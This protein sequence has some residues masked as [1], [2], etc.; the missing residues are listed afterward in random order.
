MMRTTVRL[1]PLELSDAEA[2][3]ALVQDPVIAQY[4]GAGR[5]RA[6]F[7]TGFREEVARFHENGWGLLGIRDDSSG[8]LIGYTGFISCSAQDCDGPELLCSIRQ[9]RR[10]SGVGRDA[11][12]QALEWGFRN[13]KWPRVY[14]C[15]AETNKD[16][17]A[18]VESLGFR[19]I[20]ERPSLCDGTQI[21]FRIDRTAAAIFGSGWLAPLACRILY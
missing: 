17:V 5:T 10:R 9:D 20:G 18:F 4:L 16:A 2:L 14:A 15:V 21:V 8:E 12:N 1:S 11:C 13:H 7:D 6:K 19:R 3:F